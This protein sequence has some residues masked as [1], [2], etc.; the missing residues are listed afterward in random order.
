MM[1]VAGVQFLAFLAVIIRIGS[2]RADSGRHACI[3]VYVY[4]LDPFSSTHVGFLD[5]RAFG[6]ERN[7][8]DGW[9]VMSACECEY[10][11]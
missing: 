4:Y 6:N 2:M 11:L 5:M 1:R 3:L 7:L 10:V 8:I 9:A